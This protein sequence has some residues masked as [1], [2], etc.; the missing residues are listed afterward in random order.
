MNS[1]AM[2][3]PASETH[4]LE[5]L[6]SY[7]VLDTLD[8]Q[9]YDDL[10]RLAA[11][12]CHTPSSVISLVDSQRQWF[13]SR[14]GHHA[15]QG[16]RKDSFC[17][18]A[19]LNPDTIM[20]VKDALQDPR[21]MRNPA[22]IGPPRIRFYAGAPLITPCGEA[23]GTLCV[24]DTQPGDLSDAQRDALATLARQV[25]A[26][27]ELRK[28]IRAQQDSAHQLRHSQRQLEQQQQLLQQQQ[29]ELEEVNQQLRTLSLT[30]SLTGLFNRRAFD[31]RMSEE[32][33]RSI[34]TRTPVSLL[35][36]DVDHF[37]SFNDV[38]GHSEGDI[39]LQEVAGLLKNNAR[40]YDLV[41]RYGGEEFAVIMPGT[42]TVDAERIAERLRASIAAH[43][44]TLRTV[45]VSI[46]VA[47]LAQG[48]SI[49]TFISHADQA[50]YRAK[51]QGRNCV[52]HWT[53]LQEH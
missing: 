31:A 19:I 14:F 10:T 46:G 23:L 20:V 26:Q 53:G 41:A 25:M 40:S 38:F 35:L 37:K 44:W 28:V 3:L 13:K 32:V 47:T 6:Y 17:T 8:E 43:S 12:I 50:L 2:I 45:T 36:V 49:Q 21:F 7:G 4:R 1:S 24:F 9:A 42:S 39:A 34:R 51:E 16:S 15:N 29:L 52:V 11:Y 30:D 48:D 18:H 27:L 5:V 33:E 22:V